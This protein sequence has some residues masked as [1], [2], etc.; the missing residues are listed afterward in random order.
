MSPT[1][2]IIIPVY[3]D[4]PALSRLL[5][6][7]LEHWSPEEVLVV[8][9]GDDGAADLAE[10]M[11]I[12]TLRTP[13]DRKGRARQMNDGARAVPE[14]DLLLFLHADTFLPSAAREQLETAYGDG[15]VGG[16]FSRRF[17][18]PSLLLKCTCRIADLRSKS[19]GW[20]Y[21]DQA[22]YVRRDIFETLG[23]FPEQA[24]FEDFDF[25]RKLKRQ[26]KVRLLKPPVISHARRF[27]AEGP[28]I[29]SW[30]DAALTLRHLCKRN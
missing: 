17:D 3:R 14:A 29:R 10:S 15:V 16:A 7:L 23:G 24:L 25:S 19:L 21:G 27:E 20:Y 22:I 26:G 4:Q 11:G 5:P 8:D 30:K 2:R 9:A 18:H 12:R 28:W 6:R 13:A 1:L